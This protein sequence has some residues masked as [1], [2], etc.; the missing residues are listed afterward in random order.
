M[1][2]KFNRKPI[3]IL[4]AALVLILGIVFLSQSSKL[5]ANNYTQTI[6]Y[7]IANVPSQNA[8]AAILGQKEEEETKIF[9]IKEPVYSYAVV[10]RSA[11]VKISIN[12]SATLNVKIRNTGN[13]TLL[14]NGVNP[15]FLGVSHAED[16][17]SVFYQEKLK[18]WISANRIV[19]DKKELRPG[20]TANFTFQIKAQGKSGIYR[21]FFTPIIEKIKWLEDQNIYWDITVIDPKNPDEKLA[22]TVDGKP[23]KF[24]KIKLSEQLLYAYENNV[25]KYAFQ[26][27]TGISGMDT[28]TGTFQIYNKF[29]VQYSPPYQLYMDNWMAITPSGSVGIHS[30]PYWPLKNGGRLYE[31]E[32]HLGTKVSHG[33]IR[34]SL[35][36]SKLLYDWA[37][38]GIPVFIEN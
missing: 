21:E 32:G 25:V 24:I 15:L 1:I 2:I 6:K 8:Q 3:V 20:E 29:P 16:R 12:Q 17:E 31:G 13:V 35:E 14:S 10:S 18:G 36:N 27:S 30:L 7:K 9:E 33:C 23:V 11:N 37:E 4:Y 28:P 26:T 38:V 22:I 19:M 5:G 34:V